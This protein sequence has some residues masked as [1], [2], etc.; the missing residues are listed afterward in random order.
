MG[1]LLEM[2]HQAYMTHAG[3][4]SSRLEDIWDSI[5][6]SL[7]ERRIHLERTQGSALGVWDG[8]VA[9]ANQRRLVVVSQIESMQRETSRIAE[10]LG[11]VHDD[12][13]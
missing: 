4:C 13:C 6:L 5:E 8:A 10:Q 1:S 3:S 9:V 7:Q 12:V 11:D 2:H